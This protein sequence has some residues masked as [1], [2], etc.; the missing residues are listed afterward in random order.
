MDS[1]PSDQI[2]ILRSPFNGETIKIAASAMVPGMLDVMI[3]K[4]FVRLD[5]PKQTKPQQ[6]ETTD[7]EI[8]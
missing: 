8:E 2:I 4:G 7:G 3:A 6:K 1:T 5:K